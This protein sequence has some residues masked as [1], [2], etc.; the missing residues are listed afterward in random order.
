M[1]KTFKPGGLYMATMGR[2]SVPFPVLCL[3]RKG[4]RVQLVRC[5]YKGTKPEGAEKYSTWESVWKWSA[6]TEAAN[7]M[8]WGHTVI[9]KE[10]ESTS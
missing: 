2:H 1:K 10:I 6:E 4:N 7:F 3:Q 5:N 9:A 8:G